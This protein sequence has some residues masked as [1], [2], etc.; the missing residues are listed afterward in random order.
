MEQEEILDDGG[1]RHDFGKRRACCAASDDRIEQAGRQHRA[2]PVRPFH[3]HQLDETGIGVIKHAPSVDERRG[4]ASSFLTGMQ[5]LLQ[6]LD[7]AAVVQ[8]YQ[9]RHHVLLEHPL[10]FGEG[11]VRVRPIEG[12]GTH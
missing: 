10:L 12:D 11:V 5:Q 4:A 2:V 1:V 8:R 3:K 7:A 9:M 6:M